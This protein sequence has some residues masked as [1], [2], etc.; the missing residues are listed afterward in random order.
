[1]NGLV[2]NSVDVRYGDVVV[3]RGLD[4]VVERGSI[5]VVLGPSGCGKTTLLRAVA[6]FHRLAAGSI[7]LDGVTLAAAGVH[8]PP[9]K[10]RVGIVPQEGALFPHLDV[11]RN[12]GFGLRRGDERAGRVAEMLELVDLAGYERRRPA[13]LSGGQQQ[14]VAL[15]RALAPAPALVLLDEPFAALDTSLRV[16]VRGD[17]RRVL[18]DAKATALLV[19]HDRDE[20]LSMADAVAVMEHGV[21][22]QV[23]PPDVVY[24][25]PASLAVA[26]AVGDV[27]VVPATVRDGLATCALGRLLVRHGSPEG[28]VVLALRPEQIRLVDREHGGPHDGVEA[29]VIDV[30]F[31]GQ[32]ARVTLAVGEVEVVTRVPAAARPRIGA[33]VRVLVEDHAN[34]F[35]SA[36]G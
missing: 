29:R 15:A 17:V 3:L 9:E 11:G 16:Q 7:E 5:V 1:M 30:E 10:R 25:E 33:T 20:A 8:V 14:R 24:R 23:A 31:L 34:A 22:A 26:R 36:T 19:T 13:E 28:P 4:L 6:G 21:L 35:P 2:L 27:V 12:I 18:R 32:D